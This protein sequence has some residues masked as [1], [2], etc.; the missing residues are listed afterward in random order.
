MAAAALAFVNVLAASS[1]SAF[2]PPPPAPSPRGPPPP[3]GWLVDHDTPF[4]ERR[5]LGLGDGLEYRLVMSDEFEQEGRRF[6]EK[7]HDPRWTAV[8]R[9]DHT[10]GNLAYMTPEAVTTRRGALEITTTNT[11]FRDGAYASGSVQGWNKFCMQGGVIDVSFTLP[12]A[13][14]VSGV[15][16][17]IWMLGNL[18][19]AT[20]T[21]STDGLW[22]WTYSSCQR[23]V[24][25]TLRQTVSACERGGVDEHA[26]LAGLRPGQGRG[27]PEIDV[28]EARRA[29]SERPSCRRYVGPTTRAAQTAF[30]GLRLLH[31]LGRKGP[32]FTCVSAG[33][34]HPG[35]TVRRPRRA[36]RPP[37][38]PA[39]ARSLHLRPPHDAGGSHP[40]P[41]PSPPLAP[42]LAQALHLVTKRPLTRGGNAGGAA[43]AAA[44]AADRDALPG[45]RAPLVPR[46]PLR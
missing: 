5:T 25:R 15:W 38:A 44:P 9:H 35:A 42:S 20:Y 33:F 12:G 34:V 22:P 41:G 3:D 37:R 29:R 10:N 24:A 40:S 7:F 30:E 27:V 39:V 17:A 45:R 18:G 23:D 6:D 19:R 13:A 16:P 11:G 36:R 31:T 32:H 14:G 2:D 4:D 46:P 28:L 21:L 26:R 8:S 1:S 43:A